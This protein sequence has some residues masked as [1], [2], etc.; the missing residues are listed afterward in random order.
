MPFGDDLNPDNRWVKMAH[1]IPWN[2]F[3]KIYYNQMDDDTGR[4]AKDARVVIGALIVK[5]KQGLSDEETIQTIKENPYIQYFLGYSKFQYDK[6]FEPSL[7]V[8]IRK[9]LGIETLNSMNEKFINNFKKL[10]QELTQ[11]KNQESNSKKKS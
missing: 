8:A 3:K 7:F 11:D 5:H 6:P 1:L 2:E 9:R 10:E 4:P